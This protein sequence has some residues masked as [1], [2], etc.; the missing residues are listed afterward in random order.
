MVAVIVI[1]TNFGGSPGNGGNRGDGGTGSNAS[2]VS[3]HPI[4]VTLDYFGVKD[5]HQSYVSFPLNTVQL[6]VVV[7]DGKTVANYA[8]PSNGEGIPT[9]YFQLVDLSQQ[10]VF[11]TSSV[12]DYLRV[13]ALAYSCVDKNTTLSIARALGAFER[14]M[15]TLADLYATL[16][17]TKERI[18][19]YEHTWYDVDGW[20]AEQA[21]YEAEGYG[22]L[23]LWFRIWS[24]T[25]PT[26][27]SEPLF[28]PEVTIE[29]VELPTNARPEH[30][31]F[32]PSKYPITLSLVNNEEFD[33]PIK[34]EAHSTR[35]G[36]FDHGEATVPKNG[37][38]DISKPYCWIAGES[39]ITYAIY[40]YWNDYA[41]YYYWND[42]Q[43]DTWSGTL[44]IAP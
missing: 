36:D 40:Y 17:E 5:I 24:N 33:V 26:P 7:D 20:G 39:T 2:D 43:L 32:I 27:I 1:L 18:G 15:G 12:G 41:I 23:R 8:Y 25:E 21:T 6:F 34:W 4:Q 19:W 31:C 10:T 44:N 30:P 38:L 28:I 11:D 42:A 13:S 22:D 37:R 35:I 14:S 3:N 29:D 9:K 16:P